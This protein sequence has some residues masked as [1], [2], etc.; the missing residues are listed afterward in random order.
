MMRS[1][2]AQEDFTNRP[3]QL[4]SSSP[5]TVELRLPPTTVMSTVL[6]RILAPITMLWL[7]AVVSRAASAEAAEVPLT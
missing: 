1:D 5:I 3:A 6:P 2:F 4:R 7:K